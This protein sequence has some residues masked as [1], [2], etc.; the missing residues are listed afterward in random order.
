MRK[1]LLALIC[2][3]SVLGSMPLRAEILS[4]TDPLSGITYSI[5]SSDHIATITSVRAGA[6]LG[7]SAITI[8][9][10]MLFTFDNVTTNFYVYITGGGGDFKSPFADSGYKKI[11]LDGIFE[12]IEVYAFRGCS[13]LT[14]FNAENI[15]IR[16]TISGI[17]D[18]T[19]YIPLGC[20]QGCSNLTSVK[21][22]SNILEIKSSAFKDCTK[23]Q[24][25]SC[26]DLSKV[27]KN[28]D[29]RI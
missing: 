29:K 12:G 1:A 23:L 14:E 4:Y 15:K 28:R 10:P 7:T 17:Q 5:D 21:L 3:V 24:G 26:P 11:T 6:P 19:F 8:T 2:I 18:N 27:E 16:R 9:S 22:P 13:E 25:S 20:F